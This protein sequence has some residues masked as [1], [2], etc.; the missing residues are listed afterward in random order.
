MDSIQ[1]RPKD[2]M[3]LVIKQLTGELSEQEKQYLRQRFL[4]LK[5]HINNSS[6]LTVGVK[7]HITKKS[8]QA[9]EIILHLIR[10]G[11]KKAIYVKTYGNDFKGPVDKAK[12]KI[13]R[14]VIKQKE[15]GFMRL[16]IPRITFR[17]RK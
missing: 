5:E 2:K 13:E 8:N 9:Y 7:E 11:M 14:I 15:R 6:V 12:D 16:R 1:F 10:P 3:Q 17:R 4:W